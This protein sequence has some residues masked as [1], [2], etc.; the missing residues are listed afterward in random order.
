[1]IRQIVV[2]GRDARVEDRD[3]DAGAGEPQLRCTAREPIVSD[4]R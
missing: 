3:A 2:P 4:V 1:M